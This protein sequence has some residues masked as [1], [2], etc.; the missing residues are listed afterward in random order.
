VAEAL[1]IPDLLPRPRRAE[2][3]GA[4]VSC[5]EPQVSIGGTLPPQGYRLS[6]DSERI[7]I[8]A[9][10]QEGLRNARATLAQLRHRCNSP[11]RSEDG[12]VPECEITD[13][14]DYIV[15]GVMLDVSRD[16]VPKMETLEAI[17][18]RLASW[19]IN[20]LELYIEHTFSYA[21]HEEVWRLADPFTEEDLSRLD[22]RC[23]ELGIDLVPNQ[24]T[25]G[26]FDRWLKHDR[27]RHLAI[28]PDGFEWMLGIR[29]SPTTLDPAKPGS[30]ELV[31]D[32]LTQLL[33]ALDKPTV[34]IGLDEPWELAPERSGEWA[35]WL[36]RLSGLESL[37]GRELLV[38]GDLPAGH[39]ELGPR[40]ADS[41]GD[42]VTICEW[43][44]EG[45]HPF[46]ERMEMLERAGLNRW[47]CP[48]TSSWMSITGRAFDMLENI[49][50]A[51]RAGVHG[52]AE[53]LLV[54]DW[55]D[56]GHHQ[57][58]PVSYPGFAA[59]ADLSW[60]SSVSDSRPELDLEMIARLLA[61]HCFDDPSG[62]VGEALVALGSVHRLIGPQPPN[63]SPLVGNILFPQLPVGRV[64]TPG[65]ESSELDNVDAA[66][67]EALGSLD[68]ARPGH[69]DG[70]LVLEE[71]RA[72]AAWLEFAS[73][74]ARSRLDG[75]GSL[76]SIPA[77]RR[78]ELGVMC[79][80]LQDS[81]RRLWLER[82]RPG[83]LD[84]SLAWLEHIDECYV[85][86]HAP[87]GWFGPNG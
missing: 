27:Y 20:H 41:L 15:R 21:G 28:A 64:I 54:T 25:L 71:I 48:G 53:G 12:R 61:A 4:R 74:D 46:A 70:G 42:S 1:S 68:G 51:A 58:L 43:G 35:A 24:N 16:K 76:S 10:D 34:H 17:V 78:A 40:L 9:N 32:I 86:G 65:L 39:R 56:F 73:A 23:R 66:I 85:S 50:N 8:E 67:D 37:Q 84:D 82:N 6:V 36:E 57:Y 22:R 3:T 14:P 59:S 80:S 2:Y 72:G 81:H 18:E 11:S 79:R 33:A 29:R 63:M 60:C 44:Y 13:W 38:W 7:S 5:T 69:D 87:P 19:K 62:R 26:H 49:S 31:S 55:G 83:G 75:D 47:V 77:G 45:N 52:G 30:F